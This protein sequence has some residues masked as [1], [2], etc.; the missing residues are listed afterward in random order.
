M[1]IEKGSIYNLLN[2]QCQ[3]IIPVYQR[4]YSW[5]ANVQCARLWKDIVEM[6]KKKKKHHFV[7][8][9][10]SIAEKKSVMGVQ[11]QLIIDG[12]QRMTTLSI[13][14]VALRDFL[15]EQGAG[16]EV[17]NNITN[18]V[19][20]NPSRK[21][22]DAYKMLLTDTDRDIMIKLVDG[23]KIKEDEESLIYTNYLY[24]KQKVAEETLTPDEIYE[25]IS[26]LDIVGIILDK[27]QGDEPQLIFESLNSTGMALSKSDLIRNFILMGLDNDAQKGIYNNYWKPFEDYFPQQVQG[28]EDRMDKFFRDYLTV[29]LGRTVKFESIY[30]EF[31]DYAGNSELSTS[32]ELAEDVMIYGDLYTNITAEKK[33]PTSHQLLAPIF[34]EIRSLRME[35]AYPFLIKVYRDFVDGI[36]SIEDTAEIMRLTIAYVVRRAICEIPTNSMNKTFATMK[37]NIQADDYLNSVKAAFYFADTYKRFPNDEEFKAALCERNMYSIRISKY[38]LVKLE[39]EGNKEPIPFVGYTTEHILPQNKNMRD[40]WKAALGENY[41][42]IQAKYL[43]ALGNLTLTR[44]NSEMGDKPFMEKLE[45]YRGSAMHHLNKYVVQQT[46]WNE[47]TIVERGKIL[48]ECACEVWK[49][50]R[51][52]EETLKKY[53]PKEETVKQSYDIS[54]YD[55]GNLYV[56]MLYDKL[57]EAI[58]KLEPQ[59]KVEY[60]KL[61]IA[62]KLK[63]NFVDVVVQKSR[64]RLAVNLDFDEVY[65][66]V[67]ICQDVTDLGRWGNGDVEIGFDSLSMLDSIMEIVRQSIQKQK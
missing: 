35:V 51:L 52:D 46:T 12:Q 38:F 17:D 29:K 44:Y 20:K 63:T 11:K 7:G 47:G 31:K 21:G 5:Q 41:A 34:E 2:G 6:E 40:E 61:Y 13:L 39:N 28:D 53:E 23:V 14:M 26:K 50:P 43:N 30:E 60:K 49:A 67:G 33:L 56:K 1:D 22:D 3:Y 19:L 37:N 57:Y 8:S 65:D 16:E 45:V 66:P 59:T 54:H 42:E 9:I 18:M 32:E 4:K 25:S 62:F 27:D 55:F 15:K 48:S 10:V 24:F 36:V 64:L 58:V